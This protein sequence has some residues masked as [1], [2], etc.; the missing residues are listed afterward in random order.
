MTGVFLKKTKQ[1]KNS[2]KAS[3]I[4]LNVPVTE[5]RQTNLDGE[6]NTYRNS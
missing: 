2:I 3:G 6:A 5:S 1:N 4:D